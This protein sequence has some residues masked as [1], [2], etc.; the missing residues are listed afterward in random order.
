M[1]LSPRQPKN[2][3]SDKLDLSCYSRGMGAL[4]LHRAPLDSTELTRYPLVTGEQIRFQ[5]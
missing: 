5:N 2:T 1:A 4:G 3:F